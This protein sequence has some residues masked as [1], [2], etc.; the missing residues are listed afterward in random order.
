MQ[1]S[2]IG[3][4]K[5]N[6]CVN[7]SKILKCF[8]TSYASVWPHCRFPEFFENSPHGGVDLH[9]KKEGHHFLYK[10]NPNL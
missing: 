3:F 1:K 10:H 7:D 6:S 2:K 4:K 8:G 9:S 5:G